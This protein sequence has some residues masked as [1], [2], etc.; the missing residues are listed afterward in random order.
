MNDASPH[1][2]WTNPTPFALRVTEGF[3]PRMKRLRRARGMT[4]TDLGNAALLTVDQIGKIERR[5]PVSARWP[6]ADRTAVG[7]G[8]CVE[9]GRAAQRQRERWA[10]GR[11][12]RR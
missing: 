2:R 8:Q 12:R 10:A 6:Q 7:R 1:R 5:E 3:G 4:Q 9:G 11:D